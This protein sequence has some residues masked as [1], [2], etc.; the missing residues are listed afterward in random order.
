MVRMLFFLGAAFFALAEVR[1]APTRYDQRQDGEFNVHAQLKNFLIVAAIPNDTAN[2]HLSDLALETLE[3]VIS[4][5]KQQG[6]IKSDE[7]VRQEE[8]YSVEVIQ[9][10][11]NRP[12]KESSVRKAEGGDAGAS[13]VLDQRPTPVGDGQA[14]GAGRVARNVK[15]FDFPKSREVPASPGYFAN[16]RKPLAGPKT[17]NGG[18]ARNIVGNVWNPDVESGRPGTSLKKQLPGR[19]EEED[20]ALPS[21]SADRNDVSSFAGEKQ[22]DELVLIGD[23]VENCGPGRR[24]DS[25]TGICQVDESARSLL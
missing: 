1:A 14:E 5:S 21:S 8:P 22:Q 11:E 16:A 10:N 24:R 25:S 2:D 9:L 13:N 19:G 3:Q 20:V 18:R 7:A 15:N 17:G 23:G 4:R 12:D 6:L